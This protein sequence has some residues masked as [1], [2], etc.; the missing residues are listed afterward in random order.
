MTTDPKALVNELLA[1]HILGST[2]E[3]RKRAADA[4]D[5][6]QRERDEF[7]ELKH[8]WQRRALAAETALAAATAEREGL[9]RAA[10]RYAW[11]RENFEWLIQ[12]GD[13]ITG[14]AFSCQIPL[15]V[16]EKSEPEVLMDMVA[17]YEIFAAVLTKAKGAT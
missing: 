2:V 1:T 8:A 11:W 6:L 9:E 3:L 5:Q 12:D 17:D 7:T 14:C 15:D 13:G 4:I 10:A 16:I